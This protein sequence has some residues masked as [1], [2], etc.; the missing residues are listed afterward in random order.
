MFE[1]TK[2]QLGQVSD[3]NLRELVARLCE[4]E[5]QNKGLP[6]SAVRWGGS[7][8]A[9]DGGLDIDCRIEQEDV[10]GDFVPRR[11]TGFQVKK[12]SMPPARVVEEM[13]PGGT[14]RPIFADLAIAN[15]C[16]IIV[17]LGD[18]PTGEPLRK[19]LQAMQ[20]ELAPVQHLGDLRSGFYG[21]A[22]LCNWLRQYPAVQLWV[23]EILGIQLQGWRPFGR[24]TLTAPDDDDELIC[25]PG[26]S[27]VLPGRETEPLDIERGIAG[28]RD[29]VRTSSKA[30]RIVGLSGVGKSRIVQALFED[31]V[32]EDPLDRSL[33]VYADI[34]TEPDPSARQV[35]ERLT[36]EARPAILVLDNCPT[37]THNL[38]A[39][40]GFDGIAHPPDYS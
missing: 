40:Q 33:A 16:Y 26:I 10:S 11:F 4:A 22:E 6:V 37:E 5:L 25:R 28:I 19:R 30:V 29:L 38:L 13:S 32:G 2:D 21:R 15:G 36:I 12:S 7:H 8:T 34:G 27:V 39:A 1:I 23:R 9:P 35:L 31:S 17:S 14:L 24:W 18:D 3:V 20:A